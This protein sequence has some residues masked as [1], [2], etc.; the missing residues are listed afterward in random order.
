MTRTYIDPWDMPD[1][2]L[3][4]A[5][6]HI[7]NIEAWIDETVADQGVTGGAEDEVASDV[8]WSYIDAHLGRDSVV[9]RQIRERMF[10]F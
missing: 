8:A 10:G 1:P 7:F 6:Q 9:G 5:D 4:D 2:C 3:V